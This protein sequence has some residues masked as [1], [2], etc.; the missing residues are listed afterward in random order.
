MRSPLRLCPSASG[1][2]SL[3][4]LLAA[5]GGANPCTFPPNATGPV[6]AVLVGHNRSGA[7][8]RIAAPSTASFVSLRGLRPARTGA[9]PRQVVKDR[10]PLEGG[11]AARWPQ[12][13]KKQKQRGPDPFGIRASLR[14][15]WEGARL[16][17][18]SARVYVVIALQTSKPRLHGARERIP[19]HDGAVMIRGC[20]A[21]FHVGSLFFQVE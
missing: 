2:P 3:P 18:S 19:A 9:T 17:A 6:P 12:G 20:D 7:N 13:K 5:Q 14:K 21:G 15:E 10:S 16:R 8:A 11:A 1:R 4:G